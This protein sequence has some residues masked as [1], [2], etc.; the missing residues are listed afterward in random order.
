MTHRDKKPYQCMV[1]GC[2]KSYCDA[3]SLKRHLENHHQHSSD[4]IAQ[5]MV[6]AASQAA[7]ILAEVTVAQPVTHKS[8]LATQTMNT[9]ILQASPSESVIQTASVV[10]Q[11]TTQTF[12]VTVKSENN[13]LA[14]QLLISPALNP[15]GATLV[16]LAVNSGQ[17]NTQDVNSQLQQRQQGIS[18]Q[19]ENFPQNI[20]LLQDQSKMDTSTVKI[21]ASDLEAFKVCKTLPYPCKD[22]SYYF[23]FYILFNHYVFMS[24]C[25]NGM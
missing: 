22:G 18:G 2:E 10:G 15:S 20:H 9:T 24:M 3:R 25:V 6:T 13:V 12:P 7:D 16:T 5:E 1:S 21:E 14:Q 8:P 4:L 11:N 23:T 19:Y 17:V